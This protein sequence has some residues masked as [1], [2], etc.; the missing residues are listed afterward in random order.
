M[1]GVIDLVYLLDGSWW[2]ADYKTDSFKDGIPTKLPAK[3]EAQAGIY[4]DAA[5]RCLGLTKIGCQLI[6]IRHGISIEL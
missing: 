1:E 6:Y 2:I 3:H 4:R 5:A